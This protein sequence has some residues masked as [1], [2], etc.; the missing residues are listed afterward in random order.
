MLTAN[1]SFRVTC[2][3][4]DSQH[5]KSSKSMSLLRSHL[6]EV[7][8]TTPISTESTIVYGVPYS[9]GNVYIGVITRRLEERVEEYQDACKRGD[10]KVS[11]I[12]ELFGSSITPLTGK[13]GRGKG[14]RQSH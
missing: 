7:K 3:S 13:M 14:C 11:A 6:T 2:H 12:A 9:C 5:P 1:T 8:D 10:K 4:I